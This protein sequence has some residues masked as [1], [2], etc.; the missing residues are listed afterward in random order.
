MRI[1]IILIV[2]FFSCTESYTP[3]PRALV[4]FNFANKFYEP[5]NINC[6]FSFEK[7]IYSSII[8]ID[9]NCSFN[10]KFPAQNGTLHVT[11]ISLNDNLFEHIEASRDLAFKHQRQADAISEVKYLNDEHD[12]YGMM[13]DYNGIT[14]TSTQFYLT[15]SVNHFFRGAL[16]LNSEVTDSLLPIN[17]YLKQDIIH[18]I[19]T[20]RWKNL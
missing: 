11:Y 10:L 7:P 12:V 6:N 5:I 2:L 17:N 4:K 14:A 1:S 20:F 8:Q 13:Y 3:K 19:E 9:Q 18:I 16:Y 15:D